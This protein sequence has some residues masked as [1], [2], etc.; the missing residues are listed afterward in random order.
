[1]KIGTR[2]GDI[3]A[4]ISKADLAYAETAGGVRVSADDL[5]QPMVNDI[6]LFRFA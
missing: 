5:L 3:A 4:N 2:I 6:L 1:V